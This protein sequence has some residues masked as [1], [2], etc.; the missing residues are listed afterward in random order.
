MAT[1]PTDAWPSLPY[2]A[3]APTG[4][5]LHMGLQAIGKLSLWKPFEPE[6][7]NVALEVTSRGLT[8]GL[9]PLGSGAF[10]VDVDLLAHEIRCDTTSGKT[11]RV[12]LGPMSVAELTGRIDD[13]LGAAGVEARVNRMPQEVPHPVPFDEDRQPRPYDRA[14]VHA[15]WRIL[16]SVHRV[17][18]RYHARFRGKT[19][20]IGL[21]WGT[22]DL[23]DVRYD[24]RPVPPESGAG[25]IRRNAMDAAQIE[26]GW[27]SGNESYPKPAFYS[28]TYPQPE[29]V[30]HAKVKPAGSR[31]D[32]TLRE[33]VLDY[34]DLRACAH[35]EADLLG[36]FESTYL[37]GAE[38]AGWDAKLIGPA[39]PV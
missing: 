7:A 6:W 36:F 12:A 8:T 16:V 37:A 17:M 22:F 10:S 38:R 24:G 5:L 21:M 28:F 11:G 19:Q 26:V 23:R 35:P 25:Y 15:W 13:M 3:F 31:W 32:P 30:E 9:V 20:P 1:S 4:H 39:Q 34:D 27:W 33:F 2:D 29:G 18:Q 14:L